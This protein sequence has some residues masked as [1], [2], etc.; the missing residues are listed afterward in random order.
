MYVN[1]KCT[2]QHSSGS[3]GS[4]LFCLLAA[5]RDRI[6]MIVMDMIMPKKNGREAYEEIRRLQP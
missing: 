5:N 6:D 2:R 4:P 1:L 3:S